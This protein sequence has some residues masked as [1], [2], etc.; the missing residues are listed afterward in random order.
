MVIAA[1][2]LMYFPEAD[3]RRLLTTLAGRFPGAE[4]QLDTI[5]RWFSA[6]SLADKARLPGGFVL[7]PMPWGINMN[8][9]GSI[10]TWHPSITILRVRDYA[11]GYRHRWGAY[12][13]LALIPPLRNRYMAAMIHLRFG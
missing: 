5:P 13:Y 8:E 1:G 11:E 4:M 7:P 9:I 3:V 12:G 10:A 2:L 6:R